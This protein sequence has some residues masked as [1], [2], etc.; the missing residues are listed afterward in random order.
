VRPLYWGYIQGIRAG[1]GL[2]TSAQPRAS[3]AA[4]A[5]IIL[6]PAQRH[7]DHETVASAKALAAPRRISGTGE[8]AD[9][10]R[11]FNWA[12]TSVG[13]IEQW[14][15]ALL[16]TVN[17]LVASRHP[18]FLWWG[19]QLVQFYNDA[20][21]PSIRADK[22][23]S[24]LG[25]PGAECWPE[26]WPVIFPQITASM[27]H[28]D[29][30][31]NEDQLIP[32]YRDGKLEEVYW[33]YS[34]SPVRDAAGTI[35]GTL[36]VCS[37]TTGKVLTEQRLRFSQEQYKA[38]FE[39]ASDPIFVADQDGH[40]AEVNRAACQL[41]GHPRE[42]LLQSN[43]A[44]FVAESEST[45]LRQERDGLLR[46]G[47]SVADWH[48]VTRDGTILTTEVSSTIL[49]DGRWLAFARDITER[50]R[51]ESERLFLMHELQQER[52]RLAH[53]FEQAPAFFAVLRGPEHI[54]EMTNP[55]Y[56]ELIGHRSVIGKPIREAIPEAEE[57]GFIALLDKVYQTGEPF[58]GR[59]TRI[60]LARSAGEPLEDRY[61]DFV[62]QAMRHADGTISGIIA[63]GVDVTESKRAEMALI[64]TEK[65]A[66]VGRLA[67][68]IAHE[69]NNPLE[70]I[71][72]LLYLARRS[73]ELLEIHDYL[74][75]AERELRRVSSISTQTLR[76]YKQSSKPQAVS[77]LDLIGESL[78]V[79][80]ARLSNTN[81]NVEKRKR[82]SRLVICFEGEIRQVLNNLIVNAIDACPPHGGRLLL[83]SREATNWKTGIKGLVITVA[84]NGSG[85][86]AQT[87]KRIFEP[88]F[89][90]K[91]LTGVGL[92]LW[93][94]C[95]I[96]NRH[97]GELRVHSSQ[98]PGRSGTVFNLFLP[99]DSPP[100]EQAQ[101]NATG[102]VGVNQAP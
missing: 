4:G 11:T 95:E 89:T 98:R 45:R 82:S 72:N 54:F 64:K 50:K 88:F 79:F 44:E 57:Q 102:S 1:S 51:L 53:I 66:A 25:Q 74:D 81:I 75:T 49:P 59:G 52:T 19:A 14:P 3:R 96:V 33:T 37:D 42:D 15:D 5:F 86:S 23:P 8:M 17:M 16:I 76:F 90:T 30:S 47:V 78:S 31:W 97:K 7:V 101:P 70:S 2:K 41:L 100:P 22:H 69:I 29:A 21:R 62:Y 77:C 94:S 83:R 68:S 80:R 84:D 58:I 61:L 55:L 6:Q 26:I 36:V 34:Y 91:G 13:P 9:L 12:Q 18:M 99:F 60:S 28:G 63:L 10:T 71:T 92:G 35:R 40:I 56:Q 38:L 27:T 73:D 39:M 43:Y 46:G 32:I 24:A 87:Q 65:L 67:S 20:Y 85:M 48:Y 93:V